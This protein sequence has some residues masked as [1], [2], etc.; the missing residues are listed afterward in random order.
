MSSSSFLQAGSPAALLLELG[1]PRDFCCRARLP[2]LLCRLVLARSCPVPH[3]TCIFSFGLIHGRRS[4]F[5]RD[6]PPLHH[7][8]L[9]HPQS[10]ASLPPHR[11]TFAR[12]HA[13]GSPAHTTH[14]SRLT[15]C[16]AY[17]R[18]S[19][20]M[21]TKR[22]AAP[23]VSRSSTCPTGTSGHAPAATRCAPLKNSV[24]LI[25][26]QLTRPARYAN[27]ATT[28]SRPI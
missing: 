24:S 15:P 8:L 17:N 7:P 1:P 16:P 19:L 25:G 11:P 21:M 14:I 12:R 26:R 22:S 13:H 6:C 9:S 4:S 20:S 5:S 3:H 2:D 28:T 23:F 10:P 27:S 18:T